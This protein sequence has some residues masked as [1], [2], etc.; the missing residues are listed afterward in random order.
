MYGLP[1]KIGSIWTLRR[2][3]RT[4]RPGGMRRTIGLPGPFLVPTAIG[5]GAWEVQAQDLQ[6]VPLM[7][8][9]S[10]FAMTQRKTGLPE[11]R[12]TP[13]DIHAAF[14]PS[15]SGGPKEYGNGGR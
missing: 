11:D 12:P 14:G 5:M 1:K 10:R 7:D 6:G 15:V 9:M 3:G 2:P 4:V 13:A 8:P